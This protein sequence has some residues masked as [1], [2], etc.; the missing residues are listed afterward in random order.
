MPIAHQLILGLYV[1]GFV[2]FAVVLF[3]VSIWSKAGSGR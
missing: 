1:A 3:I 2:A